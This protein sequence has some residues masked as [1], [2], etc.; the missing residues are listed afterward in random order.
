MA[1]PV[2]L[3][4][5]PLR[6]I[7][8]LLLILRTRIL[9][10]PPPVPNTIL[11][12]P[13]LILQAPINAVPVSPSMGQPLLRIRLG[14]IQ[15]TPTINPNIPNH[16]FLPFP[17][18]TSRIHRSLMTQPTLI[19]N[20]SLVRASLI[21]P[22]LT[23]AVPPHNHRAHGVLGRHHLLSN[24]PLTSMSRI[25]VIKMV[26]RAEVYPTSVSTST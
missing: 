8:H 15:T 14:P 22:R 16:P 13:P 3:T 25:S 2:V 23:I 18:P 9:I 10:L 12:P 11:L 19:S 4:I 21:R 5:P 17:T 6:T 26:L 7:H 1:V 24:N 20:P